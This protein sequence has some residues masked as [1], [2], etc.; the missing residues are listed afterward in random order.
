MLLNGT[1]IL[2]TY[3]ILIYALPQCSASLHL[4]SFLVRY[5]F[6]RENVENG[7]CGVG[8][9]YLKILIMIPLLNISR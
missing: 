8:E 9:Y 4:D 2:T 6:K 7:F 1:L 5:K 3:P